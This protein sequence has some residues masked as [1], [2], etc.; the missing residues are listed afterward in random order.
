MQLP[1]P[2]ISRGINKNKNNNSQIMSDVFE[3]DAFPKEGVTLR[4]IIEEF[5]PSCGGEEALQGL[6]TREVCERF[7]KE[8]TRNL[9]CSFCIMMRNQ[10]HPAFSKDGTVFISHAHQYLFLDVLSALQN[11]LGSDREDKNK[12]DTVIWFDLFSI[13]QHLTNDWSFEWLSTTFQTAIGNFGHVI[14][15][16]SPWNNPLPYT[17]AWCVFEVYCAATTNSKFE[18]AMSQRDR[19]AF[20]E[21]VKS[22]ATGRVNKML[23]TI[24]AEKSE[25]FKPED[26]DRIFEV[27]REE[28]GFSKLN[29]MVFECYREWVI[30][31]SLAVLEDCAEDSMEH[32]HN[33]WVEN[34]LNK[35]K[36]ALGE[37]HPDTL[38]SMHCLAGLYI[39]QGRDEDA[40]PFLLEC[41]TKRKETLGE[42]HPDTLNSMNNLAN[43]YESQGRYEEAKR[44]IWNVGA[45]TRTRW[46]RIIQKPSTRLATWLFYT[47]V[48]VVP[49]KRNR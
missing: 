47:K 44:Y 16:M 15:V 26:R 40:E 30:A 9:K 7:T 27:I 32:A 42:N 43:L 14:M 5:V 45:N 13:N 49:R 46:V 1:R 4:Y 29:A 8:P 18:I 36:E 25:S 37:N 34:S 24:R 17:R 21:D 20:L 38:D 39:D 28:V 35:R 31:T 12:L 3:G 6:L 10:G 19:E 48:K 41:W 33:L 22:D 11:H 23:A 2:F